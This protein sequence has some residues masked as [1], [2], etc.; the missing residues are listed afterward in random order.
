M[1]NDRIYVGS[2]KEK[3]EGNLINT[4]INLSKIMKTSKDYI[5]CNWEKEDFYPVTVNHKW[6]LR[7]Y[8]EGDSAIKAMAR[9]KYWEK[10]RKML[11]L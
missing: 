1:D 6:L 9:R 4:T 5:L 10:R 7:E 11:G 3:F 8:R 2:G